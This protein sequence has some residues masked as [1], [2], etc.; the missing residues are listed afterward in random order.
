MSRAGQDRRDPASAA[1]KRVGT[2]SIEAV[3]SETGGS[4]GR[5]SGAKAILPVMLAGQRVP[6]SATEGK[7][8]ELQVP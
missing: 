4:F 6:F 7:V 8:L 2:S 3:D 1:T 5:L